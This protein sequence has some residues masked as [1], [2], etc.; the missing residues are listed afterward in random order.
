VKNIQRK[1]C[2]ICGQ[3]DLE[4]VAAIQNFPI[5]MGILENGED[6]IFLDMEWGCCKKCGCV[7]LLTLIDPKTLYKIPHNPAIGKTWENH[8]KEF[9]EFVCK[10][11]EGNILDVGGANLRLAN[12]IS[13]NSKIKKYNIIDFSS[14]KYQIEK[15]NDK[16]NIFKGDIKNYYSDEKINSIVMSHTLEHIYDPLVLLDNIKKILDKDGRIII[17]VPNIEN[18]LRSGFMNALMFEHTYYINHYY[19]ERMFNRSGFQL[20]S[21]EHFSEYNSFYCFKQIHQNDH[22]NISCDILPK[23]LFLSFLKNIKKDANQIM[24]KIKKEKI[25]IFGAHI[26]SQYMIKFGVKEENIL[27]ILDN[28]ENKKNK[29]LYGTSI[30]VKGPEILSDIKNPIILLRVAQYKE[31]IYKQIKNINQNAIII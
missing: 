8:N 31:E 30:M 29:K 2:V 25:Y 23:K 5:Y 3:R 26:F 7:Q 22:I 1:V 15:V 13:P 4:K 24:K 12:L 6:E 28:D 20:E 27:Y 21:I 9:G 11:T 18:Q 16:I 17:S 10:F 19:I 14:E